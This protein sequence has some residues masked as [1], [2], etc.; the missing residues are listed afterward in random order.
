[1][2]N[3]RM[4]FYQLRVPGTFTLEATFTWKSTITLQEANSTTWD[5]ERRV[6]L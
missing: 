2:Q 5:A 1:M 3:T 6:V 4:L